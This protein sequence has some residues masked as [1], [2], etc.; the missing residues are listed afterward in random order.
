MTTSMF[1]VLFISVD[2]YK[3]SLAWSRVLSRTTLCP[4]PFPSV[5]KLHWKF[6][7]S[8]Q[9]IHCPSCHHRIVNIVAEERIRPSPKASINRTPPAP[10]PE[11]PAH[12]SILERELRNTTQYVWTKRIQSHHRK[13]DHAMP[14]SATMLIEHKSRNR[15]WSDKPI[16]IAADVSQ[17]GYE[18][19]KTD[20]GRSLHVFGKKGK[21]G[22]EKTQVCRS[23]P[24]E[25]EKRAYTRGAGG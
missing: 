1:H 3:G 16:S 10:N 8:I 24:S 19:K 23:L 18:A 6:R 5:D 12:W 25:R 13:V 11:P 15:T 22:S 21:D 7:D 2:E 17:K 20:F 4:I 14:Q 9:P